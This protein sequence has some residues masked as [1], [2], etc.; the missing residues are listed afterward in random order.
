MKAI[1]YLFQNAKQFNIHNENKENFKKIENNVY[2]K[3][4]NLWI[5]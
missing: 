4:P 2:L 1:I 3:E 5:Q